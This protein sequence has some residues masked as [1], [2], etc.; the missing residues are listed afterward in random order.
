[1][2]EALAPRYYRRYLI[3][4]RLPIAVSRLT[5]I[6]QSYMKET[7]KDRDRIP[8][9]RPEVYLRTGTTRKGLAIF[10]ADLRSPTLLMPMSEG[11]RRRTFAM[12][13]TLL[14]RLSR[15]AK[16]QKL[17]GDT[18]TSLALPHSFRFKGGFDLP[19]PIQTR[20]NE[21]LQNVQLS[22]VELKFSGTPI[23]LQRAGLSVGENTLVLEIQTGFKASSVDGLL[24]RTFQQALRLGTLFAEERGSH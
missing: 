19:L 2:T 14:E 16:K 21:H 23:G 4:V 9:P 24:E 20:F 18:L 10:H 17:S 13:Q 3:H 6:A 15:E 22:G 11:S 7:R 8:K 1:M 12:V 5:K